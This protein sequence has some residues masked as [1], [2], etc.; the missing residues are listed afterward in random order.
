MLDGSDVA[1]SDML[2]RHIRVTLY[3]DEKTVGLY[4]SL[5]N[6]QNWESFNRVNGVIEGYEQVL[7]AMTQIR[8]QMNGEDVAHPQPR[9]N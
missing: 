6:S 2:E 5:R 3:G 9:M 1:F 7:D 8:R 4:R